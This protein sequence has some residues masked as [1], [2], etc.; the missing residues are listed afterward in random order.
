MGPPLGIRGNGDKGLGTGE[1]EGDEGD[2]TIQNSK[3]YTVSRSLSQT[4]ITN[5]Q[6][7]ITNY[8]LPITNYQL[9]ITNYQLPITHYPLPITHYQMTN[10]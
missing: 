2:K 9:P 7:P 8:Q 3:E 4:A 6:L 1:D 5:Y 10:T